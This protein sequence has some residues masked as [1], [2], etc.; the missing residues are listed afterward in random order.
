MTGPTEA[1]SVS[2]SEYS[3][4]TPKVI[5]VQV[6]YRRKKSRIFFLRVF[7]SFQKLSE[8]HNL[9]KARNTMTMFFTDFTK[10]IVTGRN[11]CESLL[12]LDV[13]ACSSKPVFSLAHSQS[14]THSVETL[15]PKQK[16]NS[17]NKTTPLSS[18]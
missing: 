17:K 4:C 9:S 18:V 2:Q 6:Q 1:Q 14:E 8:I 16:T 13:I 3:N 15:L 10:K 5:Q 7:Q 11:E 12:P